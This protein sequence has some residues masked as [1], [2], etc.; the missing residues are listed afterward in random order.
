MS[1]C[2]FAGSVLNDDSSL[3][4][5]CYSEQYY[6][7]L[8]VSKLAAPVETVHIA[9]APLQQT[10]VPPSQRH[11]Q[12]LLCQTPSAAVVSNSVISNRAPAPPLQSKVSPTPNGHNETSSM[13]SHASSVAAVLS[14]SSLEFSILKLRDAF[15]DV[16]VSQTAVFMRVTTKCT[17]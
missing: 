5:A 2:Q 14:V 3:A 11:Q 16:Q 7:H 4:A 6:L 15:V 10:Q 8:I 17:S 1:V 12:H 13:S 9:I